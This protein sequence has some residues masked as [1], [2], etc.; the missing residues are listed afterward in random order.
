[1]PRVIT[2][3]IAGAALAIAGTVMQ[4]VLHNPLASPYTL[5]L[6]QA[7]AFGASFAIVMFGAGTMQSSSSAAVIVNNP[8]IVTISAFAWALL[9]TGIIVVL[10]VLTRSLR[11][12]DI[13]GVAIGS[14]S[15]PTIRFSI[16]QT[17]YSWH[18][19]CI[20]LWRSGTE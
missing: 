13:G 6:S 19:W 3:I 1:M 9:G 18:R 20:D 8:Y 4:C 2:G 15:L 14:I 12:D 10:S 7:A 11:G 17:M 16:L 5:G